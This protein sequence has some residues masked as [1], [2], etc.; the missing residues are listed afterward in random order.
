MT[1]CL[2][3][4][5]VLRWLEGTEPAATRVDDVLAERPCMSWINA[6]EVYYIV[7]R[8]AGEAEAETVVNDLRLSVRLDPAVPVRVI[9]AA[10]IKARYPMAYADA[11]AVATALAHDATLL[12]GDPEIIEAGGP[13]RVEDLR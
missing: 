1:V 10:S 4:W 13:W 12:T 8:L 9:E 2:D 11:F 7:T 3:S 5:A 6:G